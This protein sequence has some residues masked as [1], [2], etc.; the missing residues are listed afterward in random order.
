MRKRITKKRPP[1]GDPTPRVQPEHDVIVSGLA[2]TSCTF[3]HVLLTCEN[4]TGVSTR[5]GARFPIAAWSGPGGTW[6]HLTANRQVNIGRA[7]RPSRHNPNNN[8]EGGGVLRVKRDSVLVLPLH[9]WPVQSPSQVD[10]NPCTQ[11]YRI[12]P[13]PPVCL[14]YIVASTVWIGIEQWQFAY[15]FMHAIAALVSHLYRRTLCP[16]ILLLS[17]Y[18]CWKSQLPI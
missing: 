8:L 2:L 14:Q 17:C 1:G 12:S 5:A 18:I 3:P 6:L 13:P 16:S 10:P 15:M 7:S 4:R 11:N 9:H